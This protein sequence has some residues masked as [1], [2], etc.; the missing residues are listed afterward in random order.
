MEGKSLGPMKALCPSVGESQ[1]PEV[2]EGGLVSGGRGI[3]F[4][5]GRPGKGIIFEM[6]I[7]KISNKKKE[8][9]R[10]KCGHLKIYKGMGNG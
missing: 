9:T 5:E 6:Q 4:L 1:G 7:K 10:K 3:G 2:G 8:K